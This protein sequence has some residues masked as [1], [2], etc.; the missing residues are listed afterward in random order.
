MCYW[1]HL[2][3]GLGQGDA[4]KQPVGHRGSV[5]LAS[6]GKQLL[7]G[8]GGRLLNTVFQANAMAERIK[9]YPLIFFQ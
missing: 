6:Q 4:F 5:S 3:G 9:N 1:P 2:Q 7:G 8:N